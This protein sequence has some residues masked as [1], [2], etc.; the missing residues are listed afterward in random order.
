MFFEEWEIEIVKQDNSIVY[1]NRRENERLVEII[2]EEFED[3]DFGKGDWRSASEEAIYN[4]DE[5]EEEIMEDANL[6]DGKK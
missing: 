3:C 2:Q 4:I 1:T 6:S 5:R